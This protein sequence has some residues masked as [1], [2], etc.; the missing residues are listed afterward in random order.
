ML[1][2]IAI[3]ALT[4]YVGKIVKQKNRKPGLYQF[5]TVIFWIGFEFIGAIIGTLM[6]GEGM[7]RYGIALLGAGIGALISYGI[8]NSLSVLK[9]QNSEVLDAALV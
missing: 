6:Y 2:I 7:E 1:E 5:L 4:R 9:P 8:A 3:V